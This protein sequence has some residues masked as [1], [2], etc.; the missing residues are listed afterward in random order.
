MAV[1]QMSPTLRVLSV[2]VAVALVATA[3]APVL[4]LAAQIVA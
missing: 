1:N 3:A 2:I 4:L